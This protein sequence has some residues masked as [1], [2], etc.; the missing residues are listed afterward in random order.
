MVGRLGFT[1]TMGETMNKTTK[2]LSVWF[3]LCIVAVLA[4]SYVLH[5]RAANRDNPIEAFLVGEIVGSVSG[6]ARKIGD[7]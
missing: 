3:A 2:S 6:P 5:L 7:R 1:R 4:A